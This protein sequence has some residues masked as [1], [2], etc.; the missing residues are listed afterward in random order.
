[1]R[2][3]FNSQ[4]QYYLNCPVEQFLL[5]GA[6]VLGA[7]FSSSITFSLFNKLIYSFLPMRNCIIMKRGQEGKIMRFRL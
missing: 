5:T 7:Q 6:A 2:Q 1:M 3:L 4:R